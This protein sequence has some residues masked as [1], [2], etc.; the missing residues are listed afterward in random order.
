MKVTSV[1]KFRKATKHYVDAVDQNQ[2]PLLLTRTDGVTVA[3]VPLD[4]YN[5][6][7]ETEYLLSSPANAERL[8]RSMKDA[9]A[10]RVKKHTLI[11]E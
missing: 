5:S 7:S 1:S 2:E 9:R 11:E 4:T 3:V 10:G 6:W 8:E